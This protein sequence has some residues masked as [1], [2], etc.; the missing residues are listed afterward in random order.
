VDRDPRRGKG[1]NV[2]CNDRRVWRA[3]SGRI[4]SKQID[5]RRSGENDRLLHAVTV[6][7]AS[8]AVGKFGGRSF[9][10]V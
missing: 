10:G 9:R 5:T 3:E 4:E 8:Q 1:F 6:V 7:V 2:D